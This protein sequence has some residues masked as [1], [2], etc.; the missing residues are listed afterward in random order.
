M[1]YK[2]NPFTGTLDIASAAPDLSDYV[3]YVGAA[4]DINLGDSQ[5]I[6]NCQDPSNPQD[7]ATKNYVDDYTGTTYVPYTGASADVDL[8][9]NKI[10]ALELKGTKLTNNFSQVAIDLDNQTIYDG[11]FFACANYNTRQLIDPTG[12]NPT[13]D[14]GSGQLVY[15][16]TTR[17]DWQSGIISDNSGIK[18]MDFSTTQRQLFDF[19]GS[20]PSIDYG[21]YQL[22]NIGVSN[23]VP[24]LDWGPS[25]GGSVKIYDGYNGT[26]NGDFTNHQLLYT[27]T[28]T[29]NWG[30]RTLIDNTNS[31][32]VDWDNKILSGSLGEQT[33]DWQNRYLMLSGTPTLDWGNYLCY[34]S[35]SISSIDWNSRT[36]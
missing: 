32:S 6:T 13:V 36:Q 30:S 11:S 31:T 18:V 3:P 10:I 21:N 5:R 29:I 26:V 24:M 33:A 8:G 23:S 25:A 7:V 15:N 27:G 28:A 20:Y 12:T 9:A 4:A 16:A 19:G 34:D 35:G 2:F 1:G 22:Y 17:V 14:W